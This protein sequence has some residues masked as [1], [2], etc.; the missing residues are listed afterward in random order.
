MASGRPIDLINR[1]CQ[2]RKPFMMNP[3]MIHLISEIPEPAA[4]GANDFTRIAD[5]N[6][7]RTCGKVNSTSVSVWNLFWREGRGGARALW[8]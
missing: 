3:A 5:V 4:Y 1:V 8:K 7:K 6:A 2:P